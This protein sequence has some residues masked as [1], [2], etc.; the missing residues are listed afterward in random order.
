MLSGGNPDCRFFGG[1][2]RLGRLIA[3]RRGK[4]V[5]KTTLTSDQGLESEYK[6]AAR[7]Q[8]GVSELQPKGCAYRTGGTG[9][10]PVLAGYQPASRQVE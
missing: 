7:T 3:F 2:G 4:S 9:N 6:Q 10:L 5:W 1:V 8:D